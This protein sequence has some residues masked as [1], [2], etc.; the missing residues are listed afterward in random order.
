MDNDTHNTVSKDGSMSLT[1]TGDGG[2]SA[3]GSW[4]PVRT[5]L[6]PGHENEFRTKRLKEE[7]ISI[8]V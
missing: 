1:V 5:G 7:A 8:K 4:E 2:T 3:Y 6:T